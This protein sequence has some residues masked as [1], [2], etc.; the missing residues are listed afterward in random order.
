MPEPNPFEDEQIETRAFTATADSD[1]VS[2]FETTLD[3]FIHEKDKGFACLKNVSDPEG[4]NHPDTILKNCAETCKE[5]SKKRDEACKE[6]HKKIQQLLKE[7]GCP[8]T[9][10]SHRNKKYCSKKSRSSKKKRS[11]SRRRS[12]R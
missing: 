12:R 9:V 11:R 2:K 10:K 3:N 5:K 4:D 8:A 7:R 1:A 6:V